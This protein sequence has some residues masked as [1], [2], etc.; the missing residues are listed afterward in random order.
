MQ[1]CTSTGLLD[2]LGVPRHPLSVARHPKPSAKNVQGEYATF[3]NALKKVL[4]VS[5]SEL[6][7]RLPKRKRVKRS[8]ASR[9]VNARD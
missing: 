1:V 6:Q 8:S 4:S 2:F 3:E 7:S 9:A 5:H